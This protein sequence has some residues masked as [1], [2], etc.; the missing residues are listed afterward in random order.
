MSG[1]TY[2]VSLSLSESISVPKDADP[3]DSTFSTLTSLSLGLPGV[4]NESIFFI[5]TIGF[6]STLGLLEC[7][8]HRTHGV[9]NI[10]GIPDL[11]SLCGAEEEADGFSVG[12]SHDDV[13]PW[14]S[15]LAAV[16]HFQC[17]Q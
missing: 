12:V 1:K 6:F 8:C 3:S 4:K 13:W 16:L 11:R 15:C 9:Q 14:P 17:F 5:F 7:F 10:T 2:P